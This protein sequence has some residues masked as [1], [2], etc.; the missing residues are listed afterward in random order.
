M[1]DSNI[2]DKIR[3]LFS[4]AEG[5]S[6]KNEAEA[7]MNKAEALLVEHNLSMSDVKEEDIKLGFDT[8][9]V[10]KFTIK[11]RCILDIL[12]Q[13]FFVRP[14]SFTEEFKI[15][16]YGESENTKTAEYA[17]N[18]LSE[19]FHLLWC[20]ERYDH[21]VATGKYPKAKIQ[22]SF[23][24][25]LYTGFDEKLKRQKKETAEAYYSGDKDKAN[26]ALIAINDMDIVQD[27]MHTKR[28]VCSGKKRN[29]N[30]DT[31][32]DSF[33]RGNEQGS[34]INISKAIGE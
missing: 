2:S 28:S 18:F 8:V 12:S 1:K 16:L 19:A 20:S 4:L 31:L 9:Y 17:F 34:K 3:K 23:I 15:E 6:N 24:M 25:G 5:N 14:L 32:S 7:A 27:Y 10:N 33:M 11:T 13:H 29:I 21:K 26:T 30:Y 22:N